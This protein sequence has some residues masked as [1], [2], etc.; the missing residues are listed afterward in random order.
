MITLTLDAEPTAA[1]IKV[2]QEQLV[3]F[4]MDG[5]TLTIPL[6]WYPR[7]AHA[8]PAERENCQ[9]LGDGYAI[10]WPDLDEHIGVEGLI[11]GHRSGESE[12][13]FQKWLANR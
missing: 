2:E 1:E 10:E 8:T 4:L 11:A 7:L 13:S 6:A 12:Q 3:L 9:L 5:R